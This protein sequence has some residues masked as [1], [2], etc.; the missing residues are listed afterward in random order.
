M[1]LLVL[2]G[3]RVLLSV[4]ARLVPEGVKVESV[5]TL[6]EARRRLSE[7]PP[8]ALIV[9]LSPAR[10]PWREMQKLCDQHI[11]PIP[12]LYESCVFH[13]PAEAGLAALSPSGR[14]LEKPCPIA[15]LRHEIEWLVREAEATGCR[16]CASTGEDAL[17]H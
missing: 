15:R 16:A 6:S 1:R 12:V 7:H 13:S 5:R 8:E 9:D 17:R 10:L 4:V 2:D 3:S 14:F 11:P